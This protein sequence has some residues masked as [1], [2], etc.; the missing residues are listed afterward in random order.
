LEVRASI[1][2]RAAVEKVMERH[3]REGFPVFIWR[4]GAVVEIQPE[5]LRA[6]LAS[7]S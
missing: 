6:Q 4:D 1:A 5:E 2:L 3:A 7:R